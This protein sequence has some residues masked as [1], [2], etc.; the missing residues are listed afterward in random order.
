MSTQRERGRE[1]GGV[2]LVTE[3]ASYPKVSMA[4]SEIH[5]FGAGAD[6]EPGASKDGLSGS[7]VDLS[8]NLVVFDTIFL[9]LAQ[10][11]TQ[12]KR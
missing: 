5:I 1:Q 12:Q 4:V 10:V 9:A 6:E 2:F 8:V 3:L 11:K 7:R